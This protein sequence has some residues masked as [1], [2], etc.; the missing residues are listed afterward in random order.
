MHF[1][2]PLRGHSRPLGG[3]PLSH[4][5]TFTTKIHHKVNCCAAFFLCSHKKNLHVHDVLALLIVDP[6][7]H[8]T[9]FA[10]PCVGQCVPVS[11][12]PFLHVHVFTANKQLSDTLHCCYH[13]MCGCKHVQ[14]HFL[15]WLIVHPLL[16]DE[17]FSAPSAGQRTPRRATPFSHVQTFAT[18]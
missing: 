5:Q 17:H 9:H 2:A 15:S 11:G 12:T 16:H 8:D 14:M 13:S 7:L 6:G 10:A 4:V 1:A 18:K 3:K